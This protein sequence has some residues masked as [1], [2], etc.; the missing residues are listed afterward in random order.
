MPTCRSSTDASLGQLKLRTNFVSVL[1]LLILGT[2]NLGRLIW[3][4]VALSRAIA[5]AARCGSVDVAA[6]GTASKIQGI[7]VSG[8]WGLPVTG[9]TF[10]VAS[11]PEGKRELQF[12]ICDAGIGKRDAQSDC[13]YAAINRAGL[14]GSDRM[15]AP[16]VLGASVGRTVRVHDLNMSGTPVAFLA[17]RRLLLLPKKLVLLLQHGDDLLV[18]RLQLWQNGHYQF[19]WS[20][21][22]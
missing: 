1:V 21:F 4:G 3:T 22:G 6:C 16:R 5:A 14:G 17:C 8:A 20:A 12:H 18:L 9:S 7:V 2:I 10:T 13:L 15:M 11:R 19:G